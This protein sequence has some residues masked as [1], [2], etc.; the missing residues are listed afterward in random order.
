MSQNYDTIVDGDIDRAKGVIAIAEDEMNKS[1]IC[2]QWN[3]LSRLDRVSI[4]L[5]QLI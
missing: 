5:Y 1:N 2:S 4:A 3:S